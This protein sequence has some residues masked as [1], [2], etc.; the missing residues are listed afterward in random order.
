MS[1]KKNN[2][3]LYSPGGYG[4][5]SK[6]EFW[7]ERIEPE[8]NEDSRDEWYDAA[9]DYVGAHTYDVDYGLFFMSRKD[10]EELLETLKKLLE[11]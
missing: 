8:D 6:P 10:A 3:F 4:H 2:I 9:L 5:Y 11:E 7:S 1:D